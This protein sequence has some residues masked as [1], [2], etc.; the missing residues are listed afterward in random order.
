MQL[1]TGPGKGRS[2]S[3]GWTRISHTNLP[4]PPPLRDF[5]SKSTDAPHSP[6]PLMGPIRSSRSPGCEKEGNVGEGHLLLS[7]RR[8]DQML[9]HPPSVGCALSPAPCPSTHPTPTTS[10]GLQLPV[11]HWLLFVAS[12]A[13]GNARLLVV[14]SLNGPGVP[15]TSGSK[16]KLGQGKGGV[17]GRPSCPRQ[18]PAEMSSL[19]GCRTQRGFSLALPLMSSVKLWLL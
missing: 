18:L 16:E 9:P 4:P 11:S 5:P 8:W 2:R 17:N 15:T 13:Q 7:Q 19:R 12:C 10:P 14:K 1:R 3:H 6:S